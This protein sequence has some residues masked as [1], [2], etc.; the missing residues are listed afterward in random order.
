MSIQGY[1]PGKTV[2]LLKSVEI[3]PVSPVA[4]GS[5][6]NIKSVGNLDQ[7]RAAYDSTNHGPLF[8]RDHTKGVY[9]KIVLPVTLDYVAGD[10]TLFMDILDEDPGERWWKISFPDTYSLTFM[11]TV[12]SLEPVTPRDELI[13]FDIELTVSGDVT[14]E[15]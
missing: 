9:E 10:Y 4:W 6:G 13:T 14:Y 5:F 2:E 11:G 15:N 8:Y 1:Y 3:P 12:A 7:A